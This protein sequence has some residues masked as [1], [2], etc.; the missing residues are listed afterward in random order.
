[1]NKFFERLRWICYPIIAVVGLLIILDVPAYFKISLYTEQY[2]G[3]YLTMI[4][5]GTFITHPYKK[6]AAFTVID[7]LLALLAIPA[8][9]CLTIQ[10]PFIA[11]NM[12]TMTL[13]RTI[14]GVIAILLVLESLRRSMG[15]S[16]VIICSVFLLY[17]KFG[18]YLPGVLHCRS[19]TLEKMISYIYVDPN[20]LLYM[21][22]FG[23]TVGVA[24]IFFGQVLLHYGGGKAFID[25]A[26][27]FC[28]KSQGG[29]AKTA[30]VASSLVGTITGA[31]MSNVLLTGSVTIPMM[32]EAGYPPAT[33]GAVEAVASSGGQIMPPVMGIAAFIIAETLGVAYSKVALAA[34]IPAVLFYFA[35][36]VQV[37]MDAGKLQLKKIPVDQL[38][39]PKDAWK[40][41]WFIIPPIVCIIVCMFNLGVPA[42][43]SAI[44]AG[45]VALPFL[46]FKPENR[47][48]FLKNFVGALRECGELMIG[49]GIVMAMAG[50]VVGCINAT[51]L[52]FNLSLALTRLGENHVFLLLICAA[53][54]SL[55]LGMGMPSVAAYSLVA[56]LV[57]P[58]LVQYGIPAMAAHLF[59]FYFS[60]ISNIT[61][62]VAVSCFAA[63]PLAGANPTKVGFT[64]FRLAI[65]AYIVPFVFCFVPSLIMIGEVWEIVVNFALCCYAIFGV[66]V[67]LSGYWH[68][69][70]P[71][72]TRIAICAAATVVLWPSSYLVNIAGTAIITLLLLTDIKLS[73]QARR[74]K[75]AAKLST[76][77]T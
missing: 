6:G 9:L 21:L 12:G 8:G 68:R 42:A 43:L 67:A 30:V 52:A 75:K 23:C 57:A 76:C 31:P 18:N 15:I 70:V 69:N 35:T 54:A 11:V 39:K 74:E 33:A 45:A 48:N 51:G 65:A 53:V 40:N 27:L 24:F 14:C 47:R 2:L 29:S 19:F 17:T 7:L 55:I 59:V 66:C 25:F 56:I 22:S 16:L 62:P 26:L 32:K 77:A 49:I 46:A 72:L 71:T 34:L 61:P 60:V 37:H 3:I 36:F 5:F 28:G 44:I 58:A 63:A 73:I 1:M 10:Y 41:G 13:G 64:A 50:I 4:L 38:P 20:S